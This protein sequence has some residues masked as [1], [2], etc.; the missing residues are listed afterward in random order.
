MRTTFFTKHSTS[1]LFFIL[2]TFLALAWR[3]PAAGSILEI[4]FLPLSLFIAGLAVL[5]K[6]KE[7]YRQG[8]IARGVF[9]RTAGL[10]I[11]G[12]LLVM[13]LAGLLGRYA[14]RVT[15]RQM[16]GGLIRASTGILVALLVGMGVGVFARKTWGRFSEHIHV[17]ASR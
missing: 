7:A 14:A 1:I 3:F 4:V 15:T 2:L 10:E 17:E 5:E 13:L 9:I 6:H 12:I 8:Q 11:T 16:E